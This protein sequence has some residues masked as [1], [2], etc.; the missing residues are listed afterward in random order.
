M[1][2]LEI[3]EQTANEII[4]NRNYKGLFYFEV[5]GT[6]IGIDNSTGDAFT[7]EFTSKKDCLKWLVK[8]GEYYEVVIIERL[9]KPASVIAESKQEA[10][11]KIERLYDK[12]YY[13]LD[14][15]DL[16]TVDF[17]IDE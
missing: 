6:Y 4:E 10:I 5:E 14:Y 16:S 1:K 8:Y 11:D 7:E 15:D 13:V 17:Y 2:P 9:V 12:A 3:N